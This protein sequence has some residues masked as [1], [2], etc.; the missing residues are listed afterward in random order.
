MEDHKTMK[1]NRIMVTG[2]SGYIG[3]KL[4]CELLRRYEDVEVISISRSEG[5]ISQLQLECDS[6]RLRIGMADIRDLEAMRWFLRGVDVVV[7][8]AALKRVDLC[9]DQCRA[10]VDTNIIGT[11][12]LLAHFHGHT[13]VLMSTDKAVEPV[14]SYGATKMLAERLVLAK[15]CETN[16]R[17]RYMVIRSGNVIGSTGSVMDIWRHQ[18]EKRNEITITHPDMK[19]FYTS[20]EGVVKLYIAVLENGESGKIYFTPQGE[21]VVISDMARRITQMYGNKDT[22]IRYIGLRRGE[23]LVEKMRS[24]SE[25]NTVAGFEETVKLATEIGEKGEA[26]MLPPR[27][28]LMTPA[29]L[30]TL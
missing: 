21:A 12:N 7:H 18:L 2:G 1:M 13:F 30:Q 24:A 27:E 20:V 26:A 25:S 4:I 5:A 23:R 16:G 15:A 14:N 22:K 11:M 29:L 19:R 6:E 10:A 3:R 17:A 28:P 9:E 8:L